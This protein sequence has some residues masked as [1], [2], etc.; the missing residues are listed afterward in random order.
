MNLAH[1]KS[2]ISFGLIKSIVFAIQYEIQS[3]PCPELWP[4]PE[5][6]QEDRISKGT[7]NCT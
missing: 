2:N 5:M 3:Q 1:V 6:A 7:V 4:T